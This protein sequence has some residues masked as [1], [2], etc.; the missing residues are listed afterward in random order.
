MGY[1]VRGSPRRS[2]PVPAAGVVRR[3]PGPAAVLAGDPATV[4]HRCAD[5][6]DHPRLG[7]VCRH[8]VLADL[9]ADLTIDCE[10][11]L[12]APLTDIGCDNIGITL[13][14]V[15]IIPICENS[16]KMIREY[17]IVDW[18]TNETANHTQIIKVVDTTAPVIDDR[19]DHEIGTSSNACVG[20]VILNPP[21]WTDNCSS[22]VTWTLTISDPGANVSQNP[23]GSWTISNISLGDH[24]LTWTATD[25][26]GNEASVDEDLSVEDN[27]A[28]IAICDEYTT[29]AIGSDG[30]AEIFAPTFDDGS[31][32]NCEIILME[33][34]RLDNPDC[35]GFDG[36]PF[37]PTVP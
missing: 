37:A 3:V 13:S 6:G 21:S 10:D 11:P 1:R 19:P 16:Y 35:P 4:C 32:D 9:P 12:P 28:P 31:Y 36:T 14:D 8:G 27:V 2:V 18:C 17:L 20:A 26:C 30:T 34:R 5:H 24:T 25:D 29:V 15:N 23:N 33:A 22:S 7:P